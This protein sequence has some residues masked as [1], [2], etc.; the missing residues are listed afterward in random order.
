MHNQKAVMDAF[1][2]SITALFS[3]I[4]EIKGFYLPINL[5]ILLIFTTNI[6]VAPCSSMPNRP[7]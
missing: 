1:F 2:S 3:Q 5:I 7:A 6:V 4:L